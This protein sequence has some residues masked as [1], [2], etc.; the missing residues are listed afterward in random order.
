MHD[1]LERLRALV[2]RLERLPESTERDWMLAEARARLVDV[3]TGERPRAMRP[4]AADLPADLHPE[5]ARRPAV[6]RPPA[7]KT[8]EPA[9]PAPAPAP[10]TIADA[11]ASANGFPDGGLLSLGDE[12]PDPPSDSTPARW[13]RGLRG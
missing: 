4:L 9:A 10:W 12:P 2:G 1:R 7:P 13:K 8:P 5:P 6:K 3:E 11:D